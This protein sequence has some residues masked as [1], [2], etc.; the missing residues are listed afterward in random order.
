MSVDIGLY[1]KGDLKLNSQFKLSFVH[2]FW[3]M[4]KI[5]LK[6]SHE[7]SVLFFKKKRII[8]KTIPQSNDTKFSH[9]LSGGKSWAIDRAVQVKYSNI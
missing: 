9:A 8:H 1:L 4:H 6:F 3:V 5:C 2:E 7:N